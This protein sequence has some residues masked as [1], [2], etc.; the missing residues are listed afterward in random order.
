MLKDSSEKTANVQCAKTT[1][2]NLVLRASFTPE[3]DSFVCVH[4]ENMECIASM[5][6]IVVTYHSAKQAWTYL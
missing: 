5:V 3:A 4:L 6:S 1:H 2:A